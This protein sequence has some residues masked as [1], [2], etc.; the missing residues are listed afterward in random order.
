MNVFMNILFDMNE[1]ILIIVMNYNNYHIGSS[2]TSGSVLSFEP[3]TRR[4]SSESQ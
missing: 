1:K 3:C 2:C 4:R